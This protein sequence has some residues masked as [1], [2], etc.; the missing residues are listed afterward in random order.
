MAREADSL[1]EPADAPALGRWSDLMDAKRAVLC[2][3]RVG[4]QRQAEALA[5]RA[6]EADTAA[7][8]YRELLQE[9]QRRLADMK[10]R[11][12]ER[13]EWEALAVLFTP[14]PRR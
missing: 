10:R 5:V 12:R 2:E 3:R 9:R 13:A 8:R 4:E 6:A 14:P 1:A 11:A 7:E